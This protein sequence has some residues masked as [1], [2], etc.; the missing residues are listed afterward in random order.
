METSE[1]TALQNFADE[2]NLK[3]HL[4]YTVDKRKTVKKYFATCNGVSVSPEL[5]YDKLNHF[6]LGWMKSNKKN[7]YDSL[8]EENKRL[9]DALKCLYDFTLSGKG[10][11]DT[12]LND[13]E[14]ALNQSTVK[15]DGNNG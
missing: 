12:C 2:L 14:Y 4:S 3:I 7:G 6:L 1:I 15:E 11:L 5:G 8:L 9:K 13:A 10:Y